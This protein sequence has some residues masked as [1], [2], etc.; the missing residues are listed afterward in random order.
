MA[1]EHPST[2][3][4]TSWVERVAAF[5]GEEWGLSPITGRVLGWLMICEP[6]EQSAGQIA[7]AIQASRASL[8][9]NMRLLTTVGL[10]RRI[11]RARDRT[12]HYPIADGA[13][14]NGV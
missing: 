11:P 7:D 1:D 14:P 6:A 5:C 3:E 2:G 9:S 13:R 10:V 8:T 12:A 4:V